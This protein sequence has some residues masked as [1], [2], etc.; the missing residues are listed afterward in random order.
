MGSGAAVAERPGRGKQV[1]HGQ[2]DTDPC[3]VPVL[4]DV[5]GPEKTGPLG[6]QQSCLRSC[7]PLAVGT[8]NR[9]GC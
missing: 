6:H 3:H 9:D 1:Q 2:P 4:R 5:S 7:V 8:P